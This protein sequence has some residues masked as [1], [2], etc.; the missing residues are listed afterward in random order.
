MKS[1]RTPRKFNDIVSEVY[2]IYGMNRA[3]EEHQA[4]KVWDSVVGKTIAR[5]AVVEKFV[6]GTLYVHVLNPSWR[7]ELSFR[8]RSIIDRLN[9]AVGKGLVKD[10]VFR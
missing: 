6:R 3:H 2:S 1:S 9:E 5:I 10:I 4:L 8:K 7:N